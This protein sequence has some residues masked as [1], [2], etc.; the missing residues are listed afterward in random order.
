MLFIDLYKAYIRNPELRFE[1]KLL[2][3]D[4]GETLGWSSWQCTKDDVKLLEYGQW[5]CTPFDTNG[6]PAVIRLIERVMPDHIVY[7]DYKVYSFKSA[8]HSWSALHTPQL[9]GCIRM[10]CQQ[11]GLKPSKQMA[12]EAKGFCT[13][14]KLQEWGYWLKGNKHARDAIRHALFYLLFRHKSSAK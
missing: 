8:A 4:P 7:E 13:D 3:L 2:S 10:L 9:I 5:L 1:G 14:D 11:K 12:Q 6:I